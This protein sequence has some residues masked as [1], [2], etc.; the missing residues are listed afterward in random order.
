VDA[1]VEMAVCGLSFLSFSSAAAVTVA[2]A[3]VVIMVTT[4]VV[5][6]DNF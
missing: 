6:A 5:A 1:L 4:A 2:V 3:V